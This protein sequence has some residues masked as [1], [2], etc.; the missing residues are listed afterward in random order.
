MKAISFSKTGDPSV[1]EFKT[2][3][4]SPLDTPLKPKD[5]ISR[6]KCCGVNFIDTYHR[7]GLY[8]VELP[9]TPGREGAGII[10]KVGSEVQGFKVGD[11]VAYLGP[12]TYAEYTKIETGI[13]LDY[14][15]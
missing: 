13:I 7:S 4:P 5:I 14:I 9:Y 1:L 3:A 15:C 10:E 6:N 2:D 8:K 11:R 12:N